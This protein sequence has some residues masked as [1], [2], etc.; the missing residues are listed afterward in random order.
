VDPTR[1]WILLGIFALA[2]PLFYWRLKRE[3]DRGTD[4]EDSMERLNRWTIHGSSTA[5]IVIAVVILLAGVAEV[6]LFIIA[7][8]LALIA[9]QL[10]RR[11]TV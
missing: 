6:N 9:F 3:Q 4:P 7:G 2:F 11:S 5:G 1:L 10:W 8:A